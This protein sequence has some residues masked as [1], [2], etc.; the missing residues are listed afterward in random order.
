[1]TTTKPIEGGKHAG[2][3]AKDLTPYQWRAAKIVP[4]VNDGST[5]NAGNRDSIDV[6]GAGD[7][8]AGIIEYPGDAAGKTTT[9]QTLG[10]SKVKVSVDIAANDKLKVGAGGIAAKA[11]AG[12][13]TFGYAVESVKAGSLCPFEFDHSTA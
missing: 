5:R 2:P 10:R 9:I 1:M 6:A 12:D 13:K 4:G 7:T 11:A 3:S 8:V